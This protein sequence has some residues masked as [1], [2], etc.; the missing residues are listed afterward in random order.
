M[1][2]RQI[3]CKSWGLKPPIMKWIYTAMIRPIVTYACVS[4]V[5]GVN[6]LYLKKKL[7]KVQRLACLMI[8]SAFPSTPTGAL[9]MLLNITP[10]DEF[11]M[12]EAVRGSYR[13]SRGGLWPTKP[14]GSF[15][16]TKSHVDICNEA[17]KNLPLLSM[18]ADLI[19]KTKIF[20]RNFECLIKER[21]DAI[22]Y[23]SVLNKN[24]IKC[25]TDGSKINGRVGAGFYIEYPDNSSTNQAFFYLGTRSTVFQAEVFAI[26]QVAR[27]LYV[28]K[29][30]NQ[31]IVVMVDSQAAIKAVEN[32][33]VKSNTVL[34]CIKN[35][36]ALGRQ[37]HLLI[38][39]IPSHTGIYGNE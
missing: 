31:N 17:R 21:K 38:V 32:V 24:L 12:A 39:W 18:P 1:Q 4:W 7:V 36:N 5:G 27:E 8:S 23:E 29:T 26:S 33:T 2:C 34:N 20:E 15:G 35:L 19:T 30:L 6:K 37:N 3:V 22:I 14:V 10:I 9:E 13:I 25:Y 28:E 16:K 11:I